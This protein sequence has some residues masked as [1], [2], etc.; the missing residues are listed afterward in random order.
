MRAS[1]VCHFVDPQD[2]VSLVYDGRAVDALE[3]QVHVEQLQ[4]TVY[5][6]QIVQCR[7]N[8]DLAYSGT[9]YKGKCRYLKE[10]GL[11]TEMNM[12]FTDHSGI[13]TANRHL[14]ILK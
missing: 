1:V 11:R 8:I 6:R 7:R 2:H 3:L 14:H 5:G 13:K 12:T 10:Q 9:H 4:L